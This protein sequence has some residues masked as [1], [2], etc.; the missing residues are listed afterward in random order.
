MCLFLFFWH[1]I[2]CLYTFCNNIYIYNTINRFIKPKSK[3][4][5]ILLLTKM[6]CVTLS[7]RFSKSKTIIGTYKLRSLLKN[8][9][10][11]ILS[12]GCRS[13][14]G[15]GRKTIINF[16]RNVLDQFVESTL[17]NFTKM[18]I[19]HFRYGQDSFR[20]LHDV[21]KKTT[22]GKGIIMD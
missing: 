8:T 4:F 1:D 19:S 3:Q 5:L 11:F 22:T 18:T 16:Y 9:I 21:C 13:H 17:T 20:Q 14:L 10:T 6:Y 7:Y 2:I 12:C 15:C